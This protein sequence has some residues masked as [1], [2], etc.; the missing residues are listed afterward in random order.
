MVTILT[1]RKTKRQIKKTTSVVP[2]TYDDQ[3]ASKRQMKT[4]SRKE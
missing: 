2:N 3:T 1:L 4:T